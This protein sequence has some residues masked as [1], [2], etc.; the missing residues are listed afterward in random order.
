M[1]IKKNWF[2]DPTPN[3][4]IQARII[5]QIT[6]ICE[7]INLTGEDK[8]TFEHI[9]LL[10]AKKLAITWTHFNNY[11]KIEDQLLE[12]AK[13]GPVVTE[14]ED[15]EFSQELFFEFDGFIVQ[16]KSTLD[17]LVKIPSPIVGW[18]RWNLSTFGAKGEDV[19]K[20]LHGSIPKEW[21]NHAKLIEKGILS[22]H[23]EW[24]GDVIETRNKI[25]HYLRGGV[26][27]K[28]FYVTKTIENDKEI[29]VQ[30]HWLIGM[31]I[32]EFMKN[33]WINLFNLSEEFTVGFL[34]MKLMAGYSIVH[35]P[36]E[37]YSNEPS[38]K[39]MTNKEAALL[40]EELSKSNNLESLS[41]HI[42]LE[43]VETEIKS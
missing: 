6:A 32:R 2:T 3:K 34:H 23:L 36:V 35:L 27:F 28:P 11:S 24:L 10:V 4:L 30:P 42:L 1:V 20:A 5:N 38:F 17:Y 16:L 19:I 25:H 7:H 33:I 14:E 39:I 9:L 31:T 37:F 18:K 41:E 8:E 26:S 29:I 21:K 40:K 15:L 13:Q 43:A 22:H 12:E